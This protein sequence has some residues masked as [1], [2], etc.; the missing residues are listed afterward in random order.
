[1]KKN[2]RLFNLFVIMALFLGACNLPSND[3]QD[4]SA[5]SAAQTV[6]ALLSATPMMTETPTVPPI[7]TITP[8]PTSLVTNTPIASATPTC[9]LA[10]FVTDVTVP[11]GTTMTPNQNFNKK[12]RIRNIGACSWNGFSLVF[13]SG[14]SMG[15]PATKPIPVVNPGQEVDLDVDLKAPA[16][17]GTF[18]SYWR[19]VTNNNVLVP[20]VNGYQGRAFYVEVKVQA[21]PTNTTVSQLIL[22]PVESESGTVYEPAAGQGIPQTILAGD[23]ASN[24]L[25]RGYMSFNI[26]PL[27]GKT[28][29]NASLALGGCSQQNDPFGGLAG[30]WVGEVQ[31]TLPL[32]QS[33]YSIGGTGI[34]LLNSIPGPIDVKSLL[35]TRITEGKNRF[36]IRLHPAGPSDADGQADYLTCNAGSVTLTVSYFP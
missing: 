18:R 2:I 16:T 30:I 35:Q 31:Y 8:I 33:D 7:N 26:A 25:A 28:I 34:Q 19:I 17:A 9:N 20:I 27:L 24:H 10:Q 12:W 3:P 23:T 32:K 6:E 22:N 1:M 29:Q 21:V 36:Q 4:A 5:T 15:G 14:D 11:D 13:D